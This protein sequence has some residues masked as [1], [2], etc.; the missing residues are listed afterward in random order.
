MCYQTLYIRKFLSLL[1][2]GILVQALYAQEKES[3][4]LKNE[5]QKL[6]GKMDH[7]EQVFF[8]NDIK[9]LSGKVDNLEKVFLQRLSDLEKKIAR[10]RSTATAK[11]PQNEDEAKSAYNQINA[12]VKAAKF[13]EAKAKVAEFMKKYDATK[14]AGRVK[15]LQPELAVIGKKA[16]KD[17]GIEKWFQG[18]D[19]V[20]LDTGQTTLLVFWEVWCGYCKKEVPKLQELYEKQKD[21][22][23]QIVG[24]T[25]INR[26][27]T[28]EKL[29]NFMLQN[30]IQYPIAKEDGSLSKYFNVSGIPAAAVVYNGWIVWRGH[31]NRLTDDLLQSWL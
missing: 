4:D 9:T 27:A 22:G 7:L 19:E 15:R 12:L 25:K 28:E 14:S 20:D 11:P 26:S 24:L 23:L 17:W 16:P 18:Q 1:L 21:N 2:T 30:N 13:D 31:P 6:S 10:S 8:Q 29:L 5:I 3:S